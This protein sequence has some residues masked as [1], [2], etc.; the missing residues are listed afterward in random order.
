MKSVYDTIIAV[1]KT[2]SKNE[3]LAILEKQKHNTAL[4]EF[5]RVCYE[6]RIN[7]YISKVPA[8]K[9]EVAEGPWEFNRELLESI[10]ETLAERRLTGN[11][12]KDWLAFCHYQLENEWEREM[13]TML[14][15]RDVKAGFSEST[16][17]KV[18]ANTVTDVPYMRCSLPKDAK[19][20]DFPWKKGVFSQI[21]ADGMFA[22]VSNHGAGKITIESRNGSPFPIDAFPGID[23]DAQANLPA[24][25]QLHGELLVGLKKMSGI[26][27]LPRQEGNGMLNKLLKGGELPPGH[28]V[29]F[30]A[31]DM[32]PLEA[33]VT[34]GKYKVPY[35][36]RWEK[37]N[38]HFSSVS[39]SIRLIE[40][41]IA[42]SY[43]EAMRHYQYAL[44]RE[45]EGT[46]IKHPDMEWKDGTSKEQVKMKLEVS[47]EL[48]VV[49]FN[50]GRNKYV[51]MLGS[52]QCESEC[53][54]VKVN[55][56]G[57]SDAQRQ[58]IWDD[59][60]G[61]LNGVI[62]AKSNS[63]MPPENKEH[64]SL[65]LPIFLERR[66]DKKKADTLEQIQAQ[67]EA[68]VAA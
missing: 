15:E 47:V 67:F 22:N 56:A 60:E 44:S 23:A 10:I 20:K 62:T 25:M 35:S 50:E 49:G 45:L 31:W 59:Q 54:K 2:S 14:I 18:W 52:L 5:L 29:I 6:P 38:E 17:N 19:L 34:K 26:A 7:F 63:I 4:R 65:F 9:A 30:E 11:K 21:K 43:E 1:R 55:V 58:E 41:Q 46:I 28:V 3:K 27:Y 33:A 32:I 57:F 12:A 68:A 66:L 64:Y 42:H 39:G 24:G 53:G 61:W 36:K 40:T 51:G 16:I 8:P 48:R 37:L 13:L